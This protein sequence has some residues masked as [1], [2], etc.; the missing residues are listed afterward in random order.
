MNFNMFGLQRY[1]LS[2]KN[3]LFIHQVVT[4]DAKLPETNKI[5]ANKLVRSGKASYG[6][7][8]KGTWAKLMREVFSYCTTGQAG[9]TRLPSNS[10]K[11][12]R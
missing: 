6:K 10:C 2:Y 5:E 4:F 3:T 7:Q 8:S 12:C 9:E 1:S 11:Y